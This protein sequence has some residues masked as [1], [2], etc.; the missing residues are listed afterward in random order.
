MRTLTEFNFEKIAGNPDGRAC[1]SVYIGKASGL[2]PRRSPRSTNAGTGTTMHP[3]DAFREERY[4][5]QNAYP[6][7]VLKPTEYA[8]QAEQAGSEV[9]YVSG[10]LTGDETIAR[11]K[12]I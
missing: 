11:A 1:A 6:L 7:G 12:Q 4:G 9:K 2:H 10:K 5:N 3:L 8:V